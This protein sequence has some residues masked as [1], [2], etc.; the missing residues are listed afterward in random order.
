MAFVG[1]LSPAQEPLPAAQPRLWKKPRQ[2]LT[3]LSPDFPKNHS[4]A[5]HG[6]G[7]G[8]RGPACTV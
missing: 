3:K 8:R 6:A 4:K 7:T 5:R 2:R 1:R